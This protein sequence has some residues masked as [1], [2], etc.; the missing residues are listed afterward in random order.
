VQA[1]GLLALCSLLCTVEAASESP[2]PTTNSIQLDTPQQA[3]AQQFA[4]AFGA[5]LDALLA[6]PTADPPGFPGV[7]PVSCLTLCA[8]R[9]VCMT[10]CRCCHANVVIRGRGGYY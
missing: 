6:A 10:H 9:C 5:A 8:L 2:Q 1:G 7:Q 4:A 3:K